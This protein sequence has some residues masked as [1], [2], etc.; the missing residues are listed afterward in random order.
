[1]ENN[2]NHP[3]NHIFDPQKPPQPAEFEPA[4][5]QPLTDANVEPLDAETAPPDEDL[6]TF[7]APY[8][9]PESFFD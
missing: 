4:M 9:R 3:E 2:L 7:L 8:P 6:D 1:M 5:Y